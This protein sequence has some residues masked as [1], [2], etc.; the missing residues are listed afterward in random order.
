LELQWNFTKLG[1][2]ACSEYMSRSKGNQERRVER[3][4]P[5]ARTTIE[6]GDERDGKEPKFSSCLE[7]NGN[8]R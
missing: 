7:R 5:P 1:K 4:F 6:V 3:D 2:G 8:K